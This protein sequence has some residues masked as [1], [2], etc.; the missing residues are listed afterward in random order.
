VEPALEV[1]K[2]KGVE[3]APEVLKAKGARVKMEPT[4]ELKPARTRAGSKLAFAT[5]AGPAVAIQAL[6]FQAM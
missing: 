5:P 2:A 1:P 6:E 3:P 4:P